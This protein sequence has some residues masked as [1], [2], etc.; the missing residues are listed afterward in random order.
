M[1]G[2][3]LDLTGR[4][5]VV[6][7]GGPVGRRKALALRAA[8]GRVRMVCLE[9]RP[10]DMEDEGID[11]LTEEYEARHLDEALLVFAAGPAALNERV[12]AD[13]RARR[14]LVSCASDPSLGEFIT[15]ATIR[16][17]ELMIAVSTGGMVP[18][19]AGRIRERLEEEFD[20]SFAAWLALLA[21]VRPLIRERV[22]E[23]ERR[24]L[25]EELTRWEWLE[26][27]RREGSEAVRAALRERIDCL[28]DRD[29]A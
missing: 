28:E 17:G 7:G 22:E 10:A 1:F 18:A 11:W 27:V 24:R 8:G 2:V 25:W 3:F 15:P 21:E 12:V 26:R 9:P 20:E 14:V 5:A 4:L 29:R 13:A 23:E 16:S 6:V 19:L